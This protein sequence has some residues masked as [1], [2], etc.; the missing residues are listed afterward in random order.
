MGTWLT[1]PLPWLLVI[2]CPLLAAALLACRA[3]RSAVIALAPWTALPALLLALAVPPGTFARV[4]WLLFET[5]LGLDD[6]GR[7][8]LFF[9]AALW[10][11]AG[12]YAQAYL[13]EDH[14]RIRFFTFFLVTMAGNLGLILAGDMVS[15]YL[16][17][18]GMSF[19]SYGLIVHQGD[20]E[21]WRAGQVYIMLVVLG[22]ILLFVGILLAAQVVPQLDFD[23]VPAALARSPE[24]GW[25]LALL[26][27]GFG[28]KAGALPL[29]VWLPL[30]HPV[31]PTPASAVLSGVMIKAGL[32]G[33]LR[34]LPLGEIG[35]PSWGIWCLAAGLAAAFFGVV[36]GVTQD[37][38]KTALAY[39][40]ISQMGLMTVGVGAAWTVPASWPLVLVAL[41]I[42]ALHHALAKGALFLG[43]GVAAAGG[44]GWRRGLIVA[45]LLL[46]ALAL[47]GAPWTSGAVAKIALKNALAPL[48][49]TWV[50]ML[51]ILLSL[52][53][54]GTTLLMA[55][56]LFLAWPR[57]EPTASHRLPGMWLSWCVLL[58][59]V[60][61]AVWLLPWNGF[62]YAEWAVPSTSYFGANLWPVL[63]GAGLAWGAWRWG[64]VE[65][66]RVPAGDVLIPVTWL[67]NYARH[68]W[69][70][71]VRPVL[72]HWR[73]HWTF[74]WQVWLSR[75]RQ[76]VLAERLERDWERWP[77]VGMSFLVLATLLAALLSWR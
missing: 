24:R 55:R 40:S 26:W 48:P 16:F 53:A 62:G 76:P 67:I 7:V 66:W 30:A 70:A 35:L 10:L 28:I 27:A 61:G 2:G 23:Q 21:A 11:A 25:A 41:W 44:T 46:P 43:V 6:T 13:A 19:A 1:E 69:Q 74:P 52:A 3:G 50:G 15:F 73:S 38:P 12:L 17:F 72:T 18:A 64:R 51:D 58:A 20:A 56:F 71:E 49:A 63:A 14:A 68:R 4:P 47:A 9:T 60:A 29:H 36:V 77:V 59:G 54:I 75:L 37:N 33:W 57:P 5:R 22:E 65:R 39:S 42:Y 45:G 31:A 32:L 8:F 34:F